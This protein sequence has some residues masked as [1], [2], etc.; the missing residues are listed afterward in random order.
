MKDNANKIFGATSDVLSGSSQVN[1]ELINKRNAI[2]G[3]NDSVSESYLA[4][5]SLIVEKSNKLVFLSEQTKAAAQ[6]VNEQKISG[7]KG[8]ADAL[9][10]QMERI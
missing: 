9:F 10:N 1:S 5:T 6:R 8:R 7:F 2:G 4:Y 3:W